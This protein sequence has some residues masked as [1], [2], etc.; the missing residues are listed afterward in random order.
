MA[1]MRRFF[2]EHE[3]QTDVHR[4]RRSSKNIRPKLPPGEMKESAKNAMHCF[5][6]ALL[7]DKVIVI[8]K[9]LG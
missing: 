4:A 6:H 8:A 3:H 5:T 1:P 2:V 9:M 7:V